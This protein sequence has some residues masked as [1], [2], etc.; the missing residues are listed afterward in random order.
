ME[1]CV[2]LIV[3]GFVVSVKTVVEFIDFDIV[4]DI[5]ESVLEI[6]NNC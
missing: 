4:F 2:E 3:H 1:E 6:K 5:I